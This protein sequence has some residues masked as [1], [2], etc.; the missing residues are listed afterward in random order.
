MCNSKG[1]VLKG[2][3]LIYLGEDEPFCAAEPVQELGLQRLRE[4]SGTMTEVHR[5]FVYG[6]FAVTLAIA[7]G[8]HFREETMQQHL[9]HHF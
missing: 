1:Q 8:A 3:L 9:N 4:R 5:H 7:L 6:L 2:D